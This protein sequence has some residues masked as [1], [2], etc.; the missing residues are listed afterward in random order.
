MHTSCNNH[1]S[2]LVLLIVSTYAYVFDVL[3]IEAFRFT[4][5]KIV[6]PEICVILLFF[7]LDRIKIVLCSQVK[8]F[9]LIN[10][11]VFRFFKKLRQFIFCFKCSS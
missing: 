5:I 3:F 8:I 9:L 10:S 4:N 2:G 1:V 6:L 7:L 11:R